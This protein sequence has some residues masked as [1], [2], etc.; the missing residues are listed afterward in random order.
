MG[1]HRRNLPNHPRP[2]PGN[3]TQ[4]WLSSPIRRGNHR[5]PT[6]PRYW[7][8]LHLKGRRMKSIDLGSHRYRCQPLLRC[9][10][11][12]YL[13]PWRQVS[14]CHHSHHHLNPSTGSGQEATCQHPLTRSIQGKCQCQTGL[15]SHHYRCLSNHYGLAMRRPNPKGMRHQSRCLIRYRPSHH[16]RNQR[17]VKD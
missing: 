12:T 1:K 3:R 11:G 4:D 5:V 7:S 16:H 8:S 17:I 9:C 13:D 6:L 14:C 15:M 10:L 2:Y